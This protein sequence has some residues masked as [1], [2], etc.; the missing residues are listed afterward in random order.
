MDLLQ[1]AA[2]EFLDRAVDLAGDGTAAI[3]AA[4]VSVGGSNAAHVFDTRL[5]P[6]RRQKGVRSCTPPDASYVQRQ[7][8]L[9]KLS[10]V[11]IGDGRRVLRVGRKPAPSNPATTMAQ[12]ARTPSSQFGTSVEP[13]RKY[14]RPLSHPPTSDHRPRK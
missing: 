2:L 9:K 1:D 11:L 8:I 5:F 10:C 6:Q 14:H 3:A 7:R 13:A 12:I 4:F